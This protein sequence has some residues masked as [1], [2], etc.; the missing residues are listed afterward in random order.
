VLDGVG[1]L[2]KVK[3]KR[4]RQDLLKRLEQVLVTSA[5]DTLPGGAPPIHSATAPPVPSSDPAAAFAAAVRHRLGSRLVRCD[6]LWLSDSNT[7]VVVA[8]VEGSAAEQRVHLEALLA[9]T[10]WRASR[11]PLH[12]LDTAAWEAMQSL[13]AAGLLTLHARA[14]RPLLEAGDSNNPPPALTSEQQARIETLHL[15]AQRKARAA[16]ALLAAELAD[17]A[18]PAL[19]E[20]LLAHAQAAAIAR[21]FPEP[22]A[23]AET[24]LPPHDSVWPTGHRAGIQTT[25]DGMIDP[26]TATVLAEWL[27]RPSPDKMA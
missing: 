26:P 17:E 8:V 25:N 5:A 3:L 15:R 7:P 18:L 20:A 14:T 4:G 19:S 27:L 11:P 10:P 12:V 13:A 16:R 6:E 22:A 23:L 24:L 21:R 9:D 1:D 2:T